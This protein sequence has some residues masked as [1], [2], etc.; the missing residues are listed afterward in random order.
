VTDASLTFAGDQWIAMPERALYRPRTA[1]LYVA[2]LH[3]GKAATFRAHALP[4]PDGTTR[5][6]LERLS[7]AL[8]RS[9]ATRLV[10][11][12]DLL[13]ARAGHTGGVRSQLLRWRAAQSRLSIVLVK[14]N[15]DRA[16]G[17]LDPA[18]G[19][20]VVEPPHRDDDVVLHHYP[21][22]RSEDAAS[23]ARTDPWIA[24]HLHPAARLGGRGGDSVVL[25]CFHRRDGGIVLPAFGEFTGRALIDFHDGDSIL[26]I[27]DDDVLPA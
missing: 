24:G 10:V 5:R 19:V 8:D 13:H 15:H 6:T 7:D 22:E 27:A 23:H 26:V 21:P 14:G 3:L 1:T 4:L 20:V 11:L 25:S 12:G 18:L 16:S 9:G 17:A 2:D